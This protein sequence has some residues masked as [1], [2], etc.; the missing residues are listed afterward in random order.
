MVMFDCSRVSR[1]ACR[2][3]GE[4][5]K[6]HQFSDAANHGDVRLSDIDL[7][8]VEHFTILSAGS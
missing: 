5:S 7:A 4:C 6:T 8:D 2:V 1:R 3:S